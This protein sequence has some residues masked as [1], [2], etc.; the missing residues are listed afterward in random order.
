MVRWLYAE[1]GHHMAKQVTTKAKVKA[2]K[3][4]EAAET[5]EIN[6]DKTALARAIAVIA[7][8]SEANRKS[9]ELVGPACIEHAIKY[10][11]A[12]FLTKL[13]EAIGADSRR[14]DFVTWAI[15]FGP[16][17]WREG[18]AKDGVK[19]MGSFGMDT[20]RVEDMKKKLDADRLAFLS[21]MVK[22]PYWVFTPEPPVKGLSFAQMFH[23]LINRAISQ[24]DNEDEAISKHPDNDFTGLDEALK[25]AAS[26]PKPAKKAG[27]AKAEEVVLH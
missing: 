12:T 23:A 3:V 11:N 6:S 9:I 10:G 16:V 26:I 14:R 8:R 13:Y 7:A 2:A 27:K 1:D 15:H 25:I 21:P 4:I 19:E 20:A 5:M 17:V 24:R 22:S 18:K